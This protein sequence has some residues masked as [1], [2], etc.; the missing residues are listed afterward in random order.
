MLCVY[1]RITENNDIITD[2]QT[3]KLMEF[4]V[5][6]MELVGYFTI[7]LKPLTVRGETV[8]NTDSEEPHGLVQLLRLL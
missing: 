2:F 6:S 4:D 1:Q 5:S 7:A 8:S 3:D